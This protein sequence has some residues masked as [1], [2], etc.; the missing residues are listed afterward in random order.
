MTMLVLSILHG[1]KVESSFSAMGD[2]TDKKANRMF[3]CTFSAIQT[4]KYSM[5]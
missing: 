5:P 2:V 3:D 1:P 4:V